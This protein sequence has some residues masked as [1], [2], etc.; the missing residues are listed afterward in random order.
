MNK[1]VVTI[2]ALFLLAL[3]I[4]GIFA[5][6]KKMNKLNLSTSSENQISESTLQLLSNIRNDDVIWDGTF[7]GIMPIEL[8]GATLKLQYSQEDVNPLLISALRDQDKF[9]A[10]HV[11]LTLRTSKNYTINAD[12]WNGLKVQLQANGKT[13][14]N[15]NNLIELQKHWKEKLHL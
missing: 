11:L 9:V 10:A 4:L 12:E 1:S 14:F 13:S 6:R 3:S 7:V 15:G 8:V 5:M 2:L